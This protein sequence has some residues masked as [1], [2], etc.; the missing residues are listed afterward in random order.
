MYI[1]K[2]AQQFV[3][4]LQ[5]N[6]MHTM[7]NLKENFCEINLQPTNIQKRLSSL[8]DFYVIVLYSAAFITIA[9]CNSVA[10]VIIQAHSWAF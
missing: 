1:A 2:Q 7:I 10:L 6:N 4:L 5:R 8:E 3:L 9:D